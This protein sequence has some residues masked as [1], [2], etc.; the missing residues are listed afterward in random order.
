MPIYKSILDL[1][2][3][4]RTRIREVSAEHAGFPGLNGVVFI[5]V[6]EEVEFRGGHIPGAIPLPRNEIEERIAQVIPDKT[7][8]ILVYCAIGHR[9]AIAADALQ[10][11]GYTNV[12]SLD[13]GLKAYESLE[14]TRNVA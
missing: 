13:G 8:A 4:A 14:A 5:D 11:L 3:G 1:A 2:N 6:R 12:V 7:T 10:A 9:S